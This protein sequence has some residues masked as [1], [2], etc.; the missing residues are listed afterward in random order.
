MKE[1]GKV[2][3]VLSI[4]AN[5]CLYVFI[6]LCLFGVIVSIASKKDADGTATIFG[7]QMRSVISPSMEKCEYT[8]VSE[9]KIKDIKTKS[10]VFI[11]V[12]P[13][14]EE[15]QEEFYSSLKV[16]DVLTFK[17]TYVTQETITH[18]ITSIEEKATGGYIIK[19]AG[20]NKNVEDGVLVQTIDTS[21]KA[22]TNYVIGKVT[23]QSYLLGLFLWVLKT[24][25]G[26][27]CVVIVPSLILVV[28][29]SIRIVNILSSDKRKQAKEEKKELELLREKL[30]QLESAAGVTQATPEETDTTA[31]D[32]L[33]PKV[34]E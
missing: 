8:D 7:V 26:L 13:E 29:E 15:K 19:L 17:Y 5:V 10:I 12:G 23:G 18:R 11:S 21:N 6:A 20:D 16:G 31:T 24:P 1:Q 27:V 34:T 33:S 4:V 3:K 25:V 28:L 14:N 2:K 22:S 32:E 9:Y 30:K